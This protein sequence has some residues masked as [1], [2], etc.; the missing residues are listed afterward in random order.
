MRE[1]AGNRGGTAEKYRRTLSWEASGG[2]AVAF[3]LVIMKIRGSSPAAF[4]KK[5]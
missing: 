2:E 1:T 4:R 5:S 3:P